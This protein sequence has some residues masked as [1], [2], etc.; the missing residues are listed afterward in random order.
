MFR[1]N[2]DRIKERKVSPMRE[3]KPTQAQI[4]NS[5]KNIAAN[6]AVRAQA[7]QEKLE[8]SKPDDRGWMR[9]EIGEHQTYC[10]NVDKINRQFYAPAQIL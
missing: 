6:R 7:L 2:L 4:L 10:A 3:K 9:K 5:M 1:I 8:A